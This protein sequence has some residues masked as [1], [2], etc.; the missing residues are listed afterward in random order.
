WSGNITPSLSG[1]S[2]TPA[3]RSHSSV[4]AN[5]T[6]QDFA[7]VVVPEAGLYYVETD[8]LNTPRFIADDT[9][10]TVWRWDQSEPFGNDVAN[11]NPSGVGAF[12]FPLRFPGQYFDR[13]TN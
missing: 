12:D 6:G 3:S 9:G 1:Y 4:Q 13:E 2:F 11:N 8:H 7:L 10:T 5:Q